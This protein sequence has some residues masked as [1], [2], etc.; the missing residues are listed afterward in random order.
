ME[1]EPKMKEIAPVPE[2]P[3]SV[4]I[5]NAQGGYIVSYQGGSYGYQSEPA[6][7]LSVDEA[8]AACRHYLSYM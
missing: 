5:S 7:F 6:V 4:H 3:R 2:S 8:L 1:N